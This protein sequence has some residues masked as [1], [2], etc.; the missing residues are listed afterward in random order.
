MKMNGIII[1]LSNFFWHLLFLEL[2][3]KPKPLKRCKYKIYNIYRTMC[4]EI[5]RKGSYYFKLSTTNKISLLYFRQ[6][7]LFVLLG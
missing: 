3:R 4:P 1:M 5:P 2:R 6:E 7:Q